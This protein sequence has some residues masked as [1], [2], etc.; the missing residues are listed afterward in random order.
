MTR[1]LY[2][3]GRRYAELPPA[4]TLPEFVREVVYERARLAA[5]DPNGE[6]EAG[7]PLTEARARS[8]ML[9]AKEKPPQPTIRIRG[10]QAAHDRSLL[11]RLGADPE[12][13][14]GMLRCP[15]H[16][17]RAKSLS[18]RWTGDKPLLHCF[19]GCTFAEIVAAVS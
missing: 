2:G 15:A 4:Y 12:R 19:A 18:W 10:R 11:D 1:P 7:H 5:V 13:D 8:L 9:W 6:A 3:D 14:R 17:D 16:E